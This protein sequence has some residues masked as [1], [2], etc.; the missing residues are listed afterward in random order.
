MKTWIASF[1][2]S[3]GGRWENMMSRSG[4]LKTCCRESNASPLNSLSM[5]SGRSCMTVL[6]F[7]CRSPL[8]HRGTRWSMWGH[9]AP[10]PSSRQA[11]QARV[12]ESVVKSGRF[13]VLSR[14]RRSRVKKLI[15]LVT[16]EMARRLVV[17]T[18]R[19]GNTVS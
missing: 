7:K 14:M 1:I 18:M 13:V 3:D 6:S 15:S 17:P 8:C 9:S 5:R 12:T 11:A 2:L 10:F 16:V 19:R 4:L